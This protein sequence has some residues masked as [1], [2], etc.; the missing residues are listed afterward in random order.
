MNATKPLLFLALLIS[1][2]S[3]AQ[4]SLTPVIHAFHL[5]KLPHVGI[6]L[7]KDWKF[8]SGDSPVYEKPG[9]DDSY[10][11]VKAHGEDLKVETREGEGSEFTIQI[12][13]N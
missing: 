5:S 4:D 10:D 2:R 9:F 1:F 13:S 6:L 3:L 12:P 8:H 7:Y 11:I